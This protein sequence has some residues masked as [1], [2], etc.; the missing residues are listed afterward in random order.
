MGIL[1]N[2]AKKIETKINIQ[3]GHEG[4]LAVSNRRSLNVVFD[5]E[6]PSAGKG[7]KQK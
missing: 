7:F 2:E 3:R 6:K 5:Q 1:D 4:N